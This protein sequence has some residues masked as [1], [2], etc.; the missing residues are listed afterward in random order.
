MSADVIR[1]PRVPVRRI[2]AR[3]PRSVADIINNAASTAYWW[4][5]QDTAPYV[6]AAFLAGACFAFTVLP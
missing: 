2:A 3:P 1:L 4:G 5:V 6:L